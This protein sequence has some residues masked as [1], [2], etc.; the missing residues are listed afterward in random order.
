MFCRT[1]GKE[2]LDEAVICPY[3]GCLTGVLQQPPVGQYGSGF[4]DKN[5]S[6][7]NNQYVDQNGNPVTFDRYGNPNNPYLD[8]YGNH[9]TTPFGQQNM[10]S[11]SDEINAGLVVLAV[12]L[13]LAGIILGAVNQSNGK[14]KSGKAYIT[15]AVI[16]WAVTF[17]VTFIFGII[18]AFLA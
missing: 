3:C 14:H 7:Y 2:I 5:V 15:A 13:P 17:F 18:V 10:S 6:P 11:E 16:S 9:N 12:L 8:R 4:V 1:C